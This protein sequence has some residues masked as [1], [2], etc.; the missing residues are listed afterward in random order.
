VKAFAEFWIRFWRGMKTTHGRGR[1]WKLK[2]IVHPDGL[3]PATRRIMVAGAG[4]VVLVIGLGM[5]ILPGPAF[6]VIPLGLAILAT[7][8]PWARRWLSSAR[9]SFSAARKKVRNW[10]RKRRA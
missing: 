7:E 4:G 3:A 9:S 1:W 2:R 8:F 10:R 6:L 5:L